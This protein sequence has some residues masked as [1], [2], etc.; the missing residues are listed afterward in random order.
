MIPSEIDSKQLWNEREGFLSRY[1][2]TQQGIFLQIPGVWEQER[3]N[4]H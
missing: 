2:P 4:V 1:Q 3:K